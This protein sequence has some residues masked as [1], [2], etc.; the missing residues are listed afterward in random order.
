MRSKTPFWRMAIAIVAT[1]ALMAAYACGA[2]SEEPTPAPAA[3]PDAP[4][5]AAPTTAPEATPEPAGQPTTPPSATTQSGMLTVGLTSLG[6]ATGL[7]EKQTGGSP[8]QMGK[9]LSIAERIVERQPDLSYEPQLAESYELSD[10]LST[11]TVN[12]RKG[13][14]FHN[15]WGE[16]TA[17]DVKWSYGNAGVEN[18]ASIH[19]SVGYLRN[20][21]DPLRVV[22]P[23]TVEFPVKEFTINWEDGYLE[24]VDIHSKK[25]FDELGPGQAL[26]SVVG[27]GP[28]RMV[29]W[30]A[31]NEFIGEAVPDHWQQSPTFKQLRAVQV[32][33]ASTRVAMIK[34]G[35]ADIIDTVPISFLEDMEA[36]GIEGHDG[37]RGGRQQVLFFGGNFWQKTYHDSN[38]EVPRRPGFQPDEYPWI[39]D[40]FAEGCDYED[41]M[42]NVPPANPVCESMENARKVR[43]AISMAI[44]RELINQEILLGRG[45]PSYVAYFSPIHPEHPDRWV[46]PYDPELAMQYLQEAGYPDGLEV[47]MYLRP[48]NPAMSVEV[49]EAV[50]TMWANIGLTPELDRTAYQA[51]R[52]TLVER[53]T[54]VLY[55]HTGD[56]ETSPFDWPRNAAAEGSTWSEGDWN[57]GIEAKLTYDVMQQVNGN[58]TDRDARVQANMKLG[59]FYHFWHLGIGIVDLPVLY[60]YNPNRVEI[61]DLKPWEN[62]NNL[63][64]VILK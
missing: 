24:V 61:W 14:M 21:F 6:A 44:D 8:E 47:S 11:L 38:Q 32:P 51:F 53:R 15:D 3:P 1:I 46:I 45:R 29:S 16:M 30:I 23:Y 18:P 62:V 36:S 26:Q 5:A 60:F 37:A 50:A 48:D 31:D 40:P 13:V 9:A 22:D 4:P 33:E 42:N 52:P 12:L 20:Y 39:G 59:D 63:E 41:L 57:Y 35:E 7:P 54:T 19:G 10:D 64:T 28:I 34:T 2:A 25:R 27:T 55:S 58:P 17:E 56:T 49:Y 43:W